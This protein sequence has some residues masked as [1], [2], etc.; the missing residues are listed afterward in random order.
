M[1]SEY[2]A[3]EQCNSS[4]CSHLQCHITNTWL[5]TSVRS[6]S[7]IL[8]S[9]TKYRQLSPIRSSPGTSLAGVITFAVHICWIFSLVFRRSMRTEDVD[10]FLS[11]SNRY[12]NGS[13]FF[14][15]SARMIFYLMLKTVPFQQLSSC[16]WLFCSIYSAVHRK[17]T[18]VTIHSIWNDYFN[19]QPYERNIMIG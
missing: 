13:G 5:H 3:L 19:K 15:A 10:D 4:N 12:D 17:Q 8:S 14:T 6:V 9:A 1:P 18:L 7:S 16:V 11:S 2:T